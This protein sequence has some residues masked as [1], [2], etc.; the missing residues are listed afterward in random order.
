[1]RDAG[2]NGRLNGKQDA[3]SHF[4]RA[5]EGS[6]SASQIEGSMTMN[7]GLCSS[8]KWAAVAL[9]LA[10]SGCEG[11]SGQTGVARQDS[12][13]Q[14]APAVDETID[15]DLGPP[16]TRGGINFVSGYHRGYELAKRQ[17][18]PMLV[19]FTAQWC[20]YC[21][22]ME[23][24]AFVQEAVVNLARQFVCVLVDAD[25]EPDI[26]RDFR[27]KGYPTIQFLSARGVPLNRV[28]GKQPSQQLVM[29]MQAALQA[30]ARRNGASDTIQR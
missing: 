26:C 17:H 18:K 15:A 16:I 4:Q 30:V 21:H 22:Q 13:E 14:Q 2:F 19:F 5:S 9:L 3:A 6:E 27:I 23:A 7:H 24:D 11:R 10:A 29:Q 8:L 20:T 25:A 1:L 12:G 28:T